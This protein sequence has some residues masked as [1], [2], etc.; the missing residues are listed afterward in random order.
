MHKL[1][2]S[3]LLI[4]FCYTGYVCSEIVLWYRHSKILT[5]TVNNFRVCECKHHLIGFNRIN[6]A[7]PKWMF[8]HPKKSPNFI[9]PGTSNRS[10]NSWR[11]WEKKL[12]FKKPDVT[13]SFYQAS[14][15]L[16]LSSWIYWAINNINPCNK[17]HLNLINNRLSCW[18]R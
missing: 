14:N 6:L 9:H 8:L 18:Y 11:T 3:S 5:H 13:G 15:K 1:R 17:V 16:K 2:G 4:L 7:W 10:T 12:C